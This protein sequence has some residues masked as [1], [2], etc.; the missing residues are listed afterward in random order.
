LWPLPP[1]IS[2]PENL[3]VA[4][5]GVDLGGKI[6]GHGSCIYIHDQKSVIH[7]I[8]IQTEDFPTKM[9]PAEMEP[10]RDGLDVI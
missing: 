7:L 10:C 8:V 4:V 1:T 6:V 3:G 5:D 9:E 2:Q